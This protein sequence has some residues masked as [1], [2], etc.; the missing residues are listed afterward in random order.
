MITFRTFT[1]VPADRQIVV[2]L[3]P[4]TP[5]GMVELVVTVAPQE[6]GDAR[7]RGSLRRRF[8]AIRSGETRSADNERMD[9]ELARAYADTEK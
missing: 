5:T 2:N 7:P 3:P 9:I 6:S 1:E 4:E 8:G